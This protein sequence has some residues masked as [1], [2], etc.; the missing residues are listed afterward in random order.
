[1]LNTALRLEWLTTDTLLPYR[2]LAPA[3]LDER[4]GVLGPLR[5]WQGQGC[6]ALGVNLLGLPLGLLLL[7]T[8]GPRW[9]RTAEAISLAVA[10]RFRRQGMATRLLETALQA[11]RTVGIRSISLSYPVGQATEPAMARLCQQERGWQ[12]V[13]G[14]V[15]Y[16]C[17]VAEVPAFLASL[18]PFG[19]RLTSQAQLTCVPYGS[20]SAMQ[21]L[22]AQ[23]SLR[24]PAWA[25]PPLPRAGTTGWGTLDLERSQGLLDGGA[26]VGWCLCHRI[27]STAHRITIAYVAESLQSRGCLVLPVMKAVE[28]LVIPTPLVSYGPEHGIRFGVRLDNG[29]ML[30]FAERRILP[31]AQSI[32]QTM[33]MSQ[34]FDRR[35]LL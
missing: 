32:T 22:R 2:P 29:P 1:M 28:A 8:R 24:P 27:S 17:R 21:L 14:T 30:R 33:E 20:L 3:G 12:A 19:E 7:Q 26:L 15:L 9:N 16:S 4:L 31:F 10:E 5:R 35:L 25:A 11:C 18:R 34:S 6:H 13:G 23:Q